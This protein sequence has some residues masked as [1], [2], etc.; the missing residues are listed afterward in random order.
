M[1][2]RACR[3]LAAIALAL[4]A[5]PL[6][7]AQE[8]TPLPKR[9]GFTGVEGQKVRLTVLNRARVEGTL[10]EADGS[11]IRMRRPDGAVLSFDPSDL[12]R[13]EVV[14]RRSRL[15]GTGFGALTGATAGGLLGLAALGA[16]VGATRSPDGQTCYDGF[17]YGSPCTKA[18]DIPAV[19]VGGAVIGAIVGA[20]WPGRHYVAIEPDRL[21]VRVAPKRGGVAVAATVIF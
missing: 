7:R 4:T 13:V 14:E 6:A 3:V 17:G 18:S 10:I 2:N 8:E 16:D 20:I 21:A 11:T 15:R 5:V 1:G 12:R 9:S 19:M